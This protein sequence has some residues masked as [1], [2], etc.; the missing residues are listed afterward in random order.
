MNNRSKVKKRYQQ[1]QAED[2]YL[3]APSLLRRLVVMFY[4]S[5]LVLACCLATTGVI[6][7]IKGFM[8]GFETLEGQHAASASGLMVQLPVAAVIFLFF[9]VFWTLGGQTLGMQAWRVRLDSNVGGRIS[10]KQ[11]AIRLIV[12]LPSL[13]LLG[14]GYWRVLYSSDKQSW[15]DILSN[16]HLVLLPKKEKN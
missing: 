5:L 13:L 9:S 3:P 12:A 8:V 7:F 11:A 16:S 2:R 10:W 15:P 14:I 1:T 4:D 6:I